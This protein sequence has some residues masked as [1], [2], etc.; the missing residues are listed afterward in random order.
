MLRSR[1]FST[2]RGVGEEPRPELE[3]WRGEI[4]CV[5]TRMQE[6]EE[7]GMIHEVRP[8]RRVVDEAGDPELLEIAGRADSGTPEDRRTVDCAGADD[9]LPGFDEGDVTVVNDDHAGSAPV[10]D[11]Y[12]INLGATPNGEG[13]SRQRRSQVC[14]AVDIR[15]PSARFIGNGPMPVAAGWL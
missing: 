7:A 1:S 8:H 14:D 12:S 2:P 9:H 6:V 15:R 11:P 10:L 3:L 5:V 13:G 4:W